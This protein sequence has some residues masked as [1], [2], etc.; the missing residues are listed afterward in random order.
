MGFKCQIKLSFSSL[1][2]FPSCNHTG[3]FPLR[4]EQN[5]PTPPQ[6]DSPIPSLPCEKTPGPS[7]TQW[8]KNLFCGKKPKFSSISTFDSSELTLPPFVEPS[9]PNDPLLPGLS[10]SSEPHEDIPAHEPE[11]EV[12]LMQSK[13]KP[14][15]KSPLQLFLTLL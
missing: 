11:P 1:S 9:Q 2:H 14:F 8:L 13:E 7:G 3:F 5:Q 4:I 6:Q 15:G 12:A 10:P